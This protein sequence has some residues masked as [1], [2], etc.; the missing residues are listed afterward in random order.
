MRTLAPA[1]FV[2][3]AIG[4]FLGAA[5]G[6]FTT[7]P[8]PTISGTLTAIDAAIPTITVKNDSD[9]KELVMIFNHHSS[10]T[11]DNA[12]AGI[13]DLKVGDKAFIRFE[14]TIAKSVSV[15]RR[16]VLPQGK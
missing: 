16:Y 12:N 1:L 6:R 7:N 9:G 14:K 2:L 8:N 4:S 3:L 11:I 13:A 5:E 15:M 10:V